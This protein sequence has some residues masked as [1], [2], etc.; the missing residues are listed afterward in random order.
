[1]DRVS[2]AASGTGSA[3]DRSVPLGEASGTWVRR[4]TT[5]PA[6]RAA[7]VFL[8]VTAASLIGIW[9]RA[10]LPLASFWPANAVLLGMLV[11]WPGLRHWSSW[12]AAAVAFYAADLVTGNDLE[13]TTALTVPN[14]LGP[15]VGVAIYRRLGD[16]DRRLRTPDSIL[17]LV[18]VSVI[19]G[20]GAAV[21]GAFAGVHYFDMA[22]G[23][24]FI[25]WLISE[26]AMH[27]L[28]LPVLL[29]LPSVD[30]FSRRDARR[31]EDRTLSSALTRVG[32]ASAVAA[33]FG[34]SLAI[35]GP[36][37]MMFCV[38]ALLWSAS[39]SGVFE[40][41]C[42]AQLSVGGY[43]LALA[44]GHLDIDLEWFSA[45]AR[46]SVQGGLSTLALGPLIV[47][48]IAGERER[49]LRAVERLAERDGLT[50]VLARRAFMAAAEEALA[51]RKA[52]AV[53]MLDVDHFKAINDGYGHPTG[54]AVLRSIAAALSMGL[55]D[56][57]LIGRLGGEEFALV[58]PGIQQP[59][60]VGL[61]ETL[62]RDCAAVVA[63][64]V[65]LE[66][67]VS[68]GLRHVPALEAAADLHI[69]LA[70]ADS[71]LYQAK[72][73]GRNRTVVAD[74]TG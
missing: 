41:A 65:G 49:R 8:G 55:R 6:G 13:V 53:M 67:T 64:E 38:P 60:A 24:A 70:E 18:G 19:A 5:G 32:P 40:T 42:L 30:R 47:A 17:K 57:D 22:L 31:D 23:D 34:L 72:R 46:V 2:T 68:I 59:T 15:I 14:L 4:L 3:S 74:V 29:S 1:M 62:R 16:E 61:A 44:H 35:G 39:R 45:P 50:G 36:G 63:A 48:V 56:A 21:P 11:R 43:L 37:A 73:G 27:L 12:I 66:V 54:D 51:Q 7:I 58:L 26:S 28:V 52:T 10:S 20:L 33:S 9:S 71:A 25:V 69:V